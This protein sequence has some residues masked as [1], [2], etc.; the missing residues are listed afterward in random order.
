[1]CKVILLPYYTVGYVQR[2]LYFQKRHFSAIV[3]SLGP[4]FL[5]KINSHKKL[6]CTYVIKLSL[7]CVCVVPLI[8][9]VMYYEAVLLL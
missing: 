4:S 3:N 8:R 1:M 9:L 2:V 5:Q 6:V 7:H